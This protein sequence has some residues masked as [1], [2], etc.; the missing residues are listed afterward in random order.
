MCKSILIG[1]GMMLLAFSTLYGQTEVEG[2]VEGEWTVD[3]SPYIAVGDLRVRNGGHLVIE[4][5]VEILFNRG[6][7]LVVNGLLTAVGTED[8]MIVFSWSEE[9]ER[10]R[11]L[12]LIDADDETEI[13]YCIVEGASTIGQFDD[14]EARGGG[15]YIDNCDALISHNLIRNNTSN[16]R[17]AGVFAENCDPTI[18]HNTIVDNVADTNGALE[19]DNTDA[20]ISYNLV[21]HNRSQHGGGILCYRGSPTVEHNIIVENESTVMDWGCGLYF[22]WNCTAI[23]NYNLIVDNR[24]GGVYLGASS[25]ILEFSHNTI[26]DNPGRCGIL[27]YNNCELAMTNCILWGHGD[28]IWL[29]ANS[30]LTAEFSDIE[31]AEQEGIRIEE[32][33]ID[34]DPRFLDPDEGDY[35]L[36]P[37]SPCIDAG[38]PNSPEDPDGSRADMGCFPFIFPLDIRL[39]PEAI[40]LGPVGIERDVAAELRI[41]YLN[42]AEDAEPIT[43]G[44]Q[45]DPDDEEWLT[46]NPDDEIIEP[47]D[48]LIVDVMVF[49]PDGFELGELNGGLNILVNGVERPFARVPVSLFVVE[50]FGSLA[51]RVTDAADGAPVTGADVRLSGTVYHTVTDDSGRYGFAPLAAWRYRLAVDDPDFRPFLSDQFVIEPDQ[52]MVLDVALHWAACIPDRDRIELDIAPGAEAAVDITLHNPGSDTLRYAVDSRFAGGDVEPWEERCVIDA[53]EQCGDDRLQGVEFADGHF[54]VTGGDNGDGRGR[55]HI[56]SAAGEY[57]DSF[58]QFVDSPWGMRDLAWDG[59]SLWGGD[60]DVIYRFTPDGELVGSFHGPLENIAINRALTWDDENGLLWVCDVTSDLFG[61]NRG[62]DVVARIRRDD[63]LH[64]YGLATFPDDEDGAV[65]YA[66]CKDGPFDC[67]VNKIEPFENDWRFVADLETPPELKAGGICITCTWEPMS[68]VMAGILQGRREVLDQVGVW[69][70]EARTGWMQVA[71]REGAV[72]PDGDRLVTVTFNSG[73]FSAGTDLEAELAITHNGRGDSLSIPVLV[74]ISD[75]GVR[76][77]PSGEPLPGRLSLGPVYPNPFNR[78]TC[79]D[80]R[81]PAACRIELELLDTG[82]RSVKNILSGEFSAGAYSATLDAPELPS[83]VY[84]VALTT[85]SRRRIAKVVLMR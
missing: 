29:A 6:F 71:D 48:T 4:P 23:A 27:L 5:G 44:I 80:F 33:V 64:I 77:K 1:L 36:A 83:G 52:E 58:D 76:P 45:P 42:D 26:A 9:G 53:A 73:G 65:I 57:I 28:P 69:Q 22:A 59:E 79:I 21:M 85:D 18:T 32:G 11:G 39:V 41:I 46:P 19:V 12:R 55:V 2:D 62:G 25:R 72:P 60:G 70:V 40:D 15:I 67:Q 78:A 84:F 16:G 66:F 56:F 8:D 49:I 30:Q 54:Y 63:D 20:V 31:N 14:V 34:E 3:D 7:R 61:I 17:T 75:Q 35:H 37:D 10:W 51:G 47:N 43:V 82:G 50:G 81:L 68:W 74:H 38:D 24:G 13:S